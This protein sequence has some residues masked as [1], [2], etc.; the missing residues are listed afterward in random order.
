VDRSEPSPDDPATVRRVGSDP[1]AF[2]AFYRRHVGEVGRFVARRVD[3]PHTAA[4]VTAEVFLA[5]ID[6]AGRYR[7][8]PGG[9]RG[10][11]FG[12]A[13]HLA[14]ADRRH[15]ARE[16]DLGTRISGRRLLD[17]DDITRAEERIDAARR[18]AALA[19]G[20]GRDGPPP[21]YAVERNPDGSVTVTRPDLFE[22]WQLQEDLTAAGVPARVVLR[23][24]RCW[25]ADGVL[26]DQSALQ[27]VPQPPV[28]DEEMFRIRPDLIPPGAFVLVSIIDVPPTPPDVR[29]MSLGV[30]VATAVPDCARTP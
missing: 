22:P 12:I 3:D 14:A 5:V 2:E 4:D 27:G 17:A 24:P 30:V 15:A 28:P 7:G 10:W 21:A 6:S 13:R 18:L 9:A 29:I 19:P 16:R 23:A 25:D 20:L 8:S 26:A 1:D 11:L